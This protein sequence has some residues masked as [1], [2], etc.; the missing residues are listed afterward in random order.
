[1]R[2][3][4]IRQ[5]TR[6]RIGL[7]GAGIATSLSPLLHEHEAA[8]LGLRDYR[9]DLIDLDR[10][11]TPVERTGEVVRDAIASGY[12]GLN[13][14]HPCKQVVLDVLDE[15]SPGARAIGAVNTAVVS[16]NKLFGHNTDGSGFLSALRSRLP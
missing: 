16:Q 12:T 10:S 11:G 9:Y 3:S 14:T 5:K 1:M 15:L 7:V 8:A 4:D 6:H 2:H 13:V